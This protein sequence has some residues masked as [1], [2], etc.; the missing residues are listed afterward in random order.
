MARRFHQVPTHIGTPEPVV[1]VGPF[2]LTAKQF[3]TIL[4]GCALGY[5]LWQ[6]LA[7]WTDP[8]ALAVR[9][10]LALIP[11]L[12]AV[13]AAFVRLAGRPLEHWGLVLLR[14]WGWP[15]L[16]LWRSLRYDPEHLL[17]LDENEA[18]LSHRVHPRRT[19]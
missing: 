1:S 15:R 12:V 17:Q 5:H 9:L 18:S 4:L 10:V 16:L 13:A 14:F 3:L 2:S 6:M 7:W 11:A 8:A 19:H